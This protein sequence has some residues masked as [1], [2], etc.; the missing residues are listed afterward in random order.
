MENEVMNVIEGAAKDNQCDMCKDIIKY[1]DEGL[2]HDK[3]RRIV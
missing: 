2:N 1:I 3:V